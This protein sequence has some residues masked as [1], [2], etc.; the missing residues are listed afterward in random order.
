[1]ITFPGSLICVD[2]SLLRG[3][4][5]YSA[6]DIPGSVISNTLG[7]FEQVARWVSVRPLKH[8]YIP[9]VGDIVVGR[10]VEVGSKRWLVD[11]GAR[12]NAGLPLSA[13]HLSG[14]DQR[15]R[16]LEDQLGMR[17]ILAEGDI[18]CAEVHSQQSDSGI[19]LQARS[20]LYGR[21]S[22]GIL[23]RVPSSLVPRQKSHVLSLPSPLA[24]D[25]VLGVNGWIWLTPSLGL[26]N[27]TN[28]ARDGLAIEDELAEAIETRKRIAGE[29]PA[30]KIQRL[31]IA[32]IRRVIL[33][34]C[35]NGI[36][37]TVEKCVAGANALVDDDSSDDSQLL[38]ESLQINVD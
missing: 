31:A 25:I 1:M 37:I 3:H 20:M 26:G 9:E 13:M 2:R 27:D 4:G 38:K 19:I 5:T 18:I 30:T 22:N 14:G 21:L 12:T 16:T 29:T 36:P 35:E 11:I 33:F 23:L 17:S 7:P 10:I 6:D 24:V 8:R 15:R 32:K 34:C 28:I